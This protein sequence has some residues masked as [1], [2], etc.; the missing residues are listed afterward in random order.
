MA[1]VVKRLKLEHLHVPADRYSYAF[2][3]ISRGHSITIDRLESL[4]E[5]PGRKTDLL[6][7][8]KSIRDDLVGEVESLRGKFEL[9]ATA[10]SEPR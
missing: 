1:N 2:G 8:I 7:T 4:L 6:K 9:D 10:K 5:H 3:Y